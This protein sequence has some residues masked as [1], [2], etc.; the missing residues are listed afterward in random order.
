MK[1]IPNPYDEDERIVSLTKAEMDI[2]VKAME[3]CEGA[4]KLLE[5]IDEDEALDSSFYDAFTALEDIY[6]NNEV[7]A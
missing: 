4:Y 5:K 6:Q 2:V 7:Q 3:L 1:I